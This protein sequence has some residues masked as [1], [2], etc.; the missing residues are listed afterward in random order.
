MVVD[1]EEPCLEELIY[2]LSREQ[3]VEI[4]GAYTNPLEALTASIALKPD[5]AFLDLSMPHLSGTELAWKMQVCCP[6]IKI[7]FVTSYTKELEN[8]KNTP[9]SGS[10]LKPVSKTKIHNLLKSLSR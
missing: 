9:S 5:A 1:D 7:I 6:D 3:N 4:V 10:I 2:V 8:I